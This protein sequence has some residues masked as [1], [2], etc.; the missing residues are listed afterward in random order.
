M[1]LQ[2]LSYDG[3]MLC[4]NLQGTFVRDAQGVERRTL[5]PYGEAFSRAKPGGG[6]WTALRI[7]GGTGRFSRWTTT[8]SGAVSK[9][10]DYPSVPQGYEIT[11]STA[12]TPNSL[13]GHGNFY[14]RL[15]TS[16]Q[17]TNYV[18]AR[19]SAD[20]TGVQIV[21]RNATAVAKW[22]DFNGTLTGR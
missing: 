3:A 13:D 6:F 15:S 18:I 8:S 11:V 10:G 2:A 4:E 17:D 19:F 12:D 16:S 9:D 7:A 14:R 21:Y 5:I 1:G 20:F 22:G